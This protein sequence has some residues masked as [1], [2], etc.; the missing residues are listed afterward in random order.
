MDSFYEIRGQSKYSP[1]GSGL[2]ELYRILRWP[3]GLFNRNQGE[4]TFKWHI[5]SPYPI[6]QFMDFSLWTRRRLVFYFFG[7]N[8]PGDLAY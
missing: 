8:R 6:D 1:K 3:I 4:K 2:G 5:M 7:M